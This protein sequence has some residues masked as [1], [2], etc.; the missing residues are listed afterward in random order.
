MGTIR[1]QCVME[2]DSAHEIEIL[3][4][5]VSQNLMIPVCYGT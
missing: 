1:F 4:S 2:P 5:S 3:G